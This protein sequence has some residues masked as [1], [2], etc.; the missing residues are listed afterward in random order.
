MTF[1]AVVTGPSRGIGRATAVKLSERGAR[2]ALL[3][4]PGARLDEAA[5]EVSAAG[6]LAHAVPCDVASEAEVERA[7]REVLEQVGVPRVVV[8][9]AGVVLR[10]ARVEE[11]RVADWDRVIA[12]N[13]RGPFL[14]ARA[15]LPA[16]RKAGRGRLVQVSS[17]SGTIGSPGAASYAASKW[18][19]LGFTKSLAEELRGTGLQAVAIAP[20]SVDTDMLAGSGFPPA[21]TAKDVAEM[22]VYAALDA[23]DSVNGSAIEMF[24]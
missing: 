17:I 3:G 6:V 18:A 16:M 14:I 15:F 7:A 11:T 1:V 5:R 9:N 10:G 12:V 21:M 23:P 8:N 13:L 20:G 4:L 2:V 19:L 22:I 24:G